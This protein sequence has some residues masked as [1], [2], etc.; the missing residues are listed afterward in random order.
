[1]AHMSI[2]LKKGREELEEQRK[3]VLKKESVMKEL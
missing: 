2:L 1:M 3:I